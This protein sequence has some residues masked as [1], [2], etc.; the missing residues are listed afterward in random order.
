MPAVVYHKI[1]ANSEQNLQTAAGLCHTTVQYDCHADTDE[2][3]DAL[4]EVIRLALQ[5]YR[6]PAGDE[7]VNCITVSGERD[8]DDPPL[9]GSDQAR[10]THQIDFLVSHQEAIPA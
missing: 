8:E 4:K 1:A 7:T 3:A 6:G 5:G 10:Y 9:D 2:A